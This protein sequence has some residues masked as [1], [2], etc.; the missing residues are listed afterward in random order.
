MRLMAAAAV[1]LTVACRHAPPAT[2]PENRVVV[3]DVRLEG[4]EGLPVRVFEEFR[5]RLPVRAGSELTEKIEQDTG[6]RAVEILQDSGYPYAQVRS[7]REPTEPGR[8]RLTLRAEP[9]PT[10]IF[11]RIDIA[12][13]RTVDDR[14]IRRR[15][16][17]VPGDLFR[18]SAILTTQQRIGALGLFKSVEIRAQDVDQKPSAVPTLITVEERSPWRWKLGLGYA[19]GEQL[20]LDA[21]IAHLN[22]LG[23]ARRFEVDGSISR[24]ERAAGLSL[25]QTE[26]WHPALS[27]SLQAR[28]REVDESAFFVTSSGGQA[29]VTWQ[30]RSGLTG[31]FA[32]AVALERSEVERGLDLLIGLQDG[33]LSAWSIDLEHRAPPSAAAPGQS[34]PS[35]PLSR[36]LLLH[37]EQAGGWM[38]GTFNYASAIGEVRLYR[39]IAR[40]RVQLAGRLRFGGI[41]PR[42]SEADIPLLKRFFLGG[43]SEMRGWGIYEVSPLSSTGTAVGGKSLFSATA[44]ARFLLMPRLTGAVFL[45][46]GN[47]WQDPWRMYLRDLLYD[48]GAGVR[49]STPFGLVR[50]DL[51]YQLK[52]LD[53]LRIDG[54]PQSHRWRINFGL[55]EAF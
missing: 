41:D 13:N 31:T 45:E 42:I 20:S 51:G 37:V 25:T 16:A 8:V 28:H 4:F 36:V 52:M 24:I 17:Y 53:G 15:V 26:V 39:P 27:L 23:D 7:V 30:W 21:G 49:V 3:D 55:G 44:E 40:E 9:G 29:G 50:I 34:Q 43:S 54:R 10:G 38:P 35:G 2:A 33:T 11:G 22:F 18:R 47:V 48:A 14:I 12:G 32:Y 1:L 19:A 6:N 5:D 46:A